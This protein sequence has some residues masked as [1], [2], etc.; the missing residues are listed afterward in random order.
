VQ[1]AVTAAVPESATDL[2]LVPHSNAG[3]FLPVI[4]ADSTVR[5]RV[6]GAVFVD[7]ALPA[8]SGSTAVAAPEFLEFLR[9]KAGHGLLPPWT[10]W[11][12]EADVASLFPDDA[13]RAAV[14]AEQPQL[15]LRYY[16]ER[17]PVPQGWDRLPCAF[18]WFGPPYDELA[19]QAEHRGWRVRRLPGEHLHAVVD[20]IGVTDAILDLSA[21]WCDE[22]RSRGARPPE[23]SPR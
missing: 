20:P 13:T 9:A 23:P 4:A 16:E 15:P 2:I 22:R 7:A 21:A 14:V 11:W 10:D 19:G 8:I 5:D 3:L 12:N 18:L 17:V 1:D 6:R